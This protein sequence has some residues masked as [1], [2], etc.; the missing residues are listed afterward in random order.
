MKGIK[1]ERV[2]NNALAVRVHAVEGQKT[3][4]SLLSRKVL[5][6]I[7]GFLQNC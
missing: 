1:K 5:K 3:S 4:L 2:N 7:I 6:L